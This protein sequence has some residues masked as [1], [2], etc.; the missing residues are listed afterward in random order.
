MT[1]ALRLVAYLIADT[2][3]AGVQASSIW[4]KVQGKLEGED[5]YEALDK[6]DRLEVYEEYMRWGP[7]LWHC[8][9][10]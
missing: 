8:H 7:R 3:A 6:I 5:A 1:A 4:R 2:V 9:W 10:G